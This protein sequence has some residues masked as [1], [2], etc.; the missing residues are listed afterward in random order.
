MI[1]MT[2]SNSIRVNPRGGDERP[3]D[4]LSR[5]ERT[6]SYSRLACRSRM[7]Q[8]GVP[9][10]GGGIASVARARPKGGP[11]AESAAAD[12]RRHGSAGHALPVLPP[13]GGRL[14]GGRRRP[15]GPPLPRRDARDPARRRHPLGHHP[16]AAGLPHQGDRRLPRRRS[17]GVRRAVPLRRPRPGVPPLRPGPGAHH[18]PLLRG[19]QA[20]GGRLP[21]RGDRRRGRRAQRPDHDHRRQ[22][23][24]G[25]HPVRRQLRRPGRASSTA[26]WSAPAPGTTTPSCSSSSS[27]CSRP[28][29]RRPAAEVPAT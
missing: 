13:A 21:R 9:A 16:R 7:P 29:P 2:T 12:R 19:Q 28:P 26:T 1:A 3:W 18:P 24:P 23:R 4:L 25:H 15:E 27:S 22:V 14:R 6:P 17:E 8:D 20:G 5:G 11:H 10:A